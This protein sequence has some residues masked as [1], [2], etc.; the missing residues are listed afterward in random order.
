MNKVIKFSALAAACAAFT[1]LSTSIAHADD[2]VVSADDDI[3]VESYDYV[4][5]DDYYYNNGESIQARDDVVVYDIASEPVLED[6]VVSVENASVG[7]DVV[8]CDISSDNF[9]VSVDS[10]T[11]TYEPVSS[12]DFSAD[13]SY[14]FYE[15]GVTDVVSADDGSYYEADYDRGG[16]SQIKVTYEMRAVLNGINALRVKAGAGKLKMSDALNGVADK[17]VR[18]IA[19]KFDHIRPNGRS[20]SSILIENGISYG[21]TGENIAFGISDPNDVVSAW[22]RSKTHNKC[23]MNGNYR[24]AGIGM[25]VSGGY[26]Y[27]A[28]I[29]TD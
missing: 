21:R 29:L 1:L 5:V 27:W 19:R 9:D 11:V 20:A 17:R 26:T 13:I 4:S 25:V 7:S 12:Y 28:L 15:E 22:S 8:V 16:S 24:Q 14:D 2:Y 10:Y 18:E 6:F 23:M 3:S